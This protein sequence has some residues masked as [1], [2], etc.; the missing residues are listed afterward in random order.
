MV[1]QVKLL[2]YVRKE[3]DMDEKENSGKYQWRCTVCGHIYDNDSIP[4]D[5]ICPVCGSPMPKFERE[6]KE[7]MARDM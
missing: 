3:T 1:Y 4:R 2:P 5:Y 6:E 7:T